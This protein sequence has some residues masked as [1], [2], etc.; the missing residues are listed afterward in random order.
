MRTRYAALAATFVLAAAL[1]A[2]ILLTSNA[3]EQPTSI[4]QQTAPHSPRDAPD[5]PV[6]P[7]PPDRCTTPTDPTCIRAVYKGAPDDY[8]QVQDIPDSVLIQPDD[9]GRYQVERGQQITVVT[10]APLPTDYTRFY[11]QRQPL[12]VAVSPTSFEQLI[13]PVGTTYTFTVAANEAGSNLITF[14]L[15]EARPRP[16]PRPG[17]K[18]E[19]G[20]IVVTTNF[21]VPTLRYDTLDITGAAT[22]PGSY[23]F[24]KTAGDASSAIGNFSDSSLRSVEL[25]V[26]PTDASGASR[27]DFYDM[28]QVG[29]MFDY[30]TDNGGVCMVRFK[31][32]SIGMTTS[33]R[34]FG[35]EQATQYRTWCLPFVDDPAA[36]LNV[37]FV[38]RVRPGIVGA[39]G[40]RVLLNGE[41]VG[42]GT[43]RIDN[44]WPW[45]IDVPAGMTIVYHGV[46]INE[47]DVNR[48]NQPASTLVLED[49]DTGSVLH[50]DPSN[51]HTGQIYIIGPHPRTLFEQLIA[52]I[53][54]Q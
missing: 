51:G 1:A 41:P 17:Q 3:A 43:Y 19:L 47:L 26:H 9:D 18:P 14:N 20:D 50:I 8:A 53:R 2:T 46:A 45:V 32:T 49:V 25:R 4:A 31:V 23:A 24:L 21:L 7:M 37:G 10:A 15:T 38:W 48:P 36:P 54:R 44:Y 52:S 16:R 27:A 42:Q 29:D 28:V 13:Q 40:V 34:T 33:P 35:I 39:D 6:T 11:L 12:Q 30:R 22:T 5:A